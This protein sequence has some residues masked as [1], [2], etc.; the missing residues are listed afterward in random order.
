MLYRFHHMV[1]IVALRQQRQGEMTAQDH[2][3][4]LW[5][6]GNL[7]SADNRGQPRRSEFAVAPPAKVA[8]PKPVSREETL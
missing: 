7:D 3:R 4:G 2:N 1:K 6:L 5:S 8:L